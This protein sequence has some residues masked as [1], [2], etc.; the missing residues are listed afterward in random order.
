MQH[1]K[2]KNAENYRE[3]IVKTHHVW[4]VVIL[5]LVL[6]FSSFWLGR[7]YESHM[8]KY[9]PSIHYDKRG[10]SIADS[11]STMDAE[12]MDQ[13]LT[14]FDKLESESMPDD[15]LTYKKRETQRRNRESQ[16]TTKQKNVSIK[17]AP[18]TSYY[19]IQV[20]AGNRKSTALKDSEKLLKMGF[21]SYVEEERGASGTLY[22]VRVGKF[23]SKKQALT[24]ESKLKNQ[25]YKTWIL[26]VE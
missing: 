22:K 11:S 20:L 25:G 12:E 3:F 9:N 16:K 2:R 15:P 4:I 6:C 7:W 10:T 26:K 13:M 19:T 23:S 8:E 14:F 21:A 18:R 24:V 17:E 1:L 5:L